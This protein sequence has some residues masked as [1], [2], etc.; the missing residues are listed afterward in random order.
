MRDRKQIVWCQVTDK[1]AVLF[2]F[3]PRKSMAYGWIQVTEWH[4][5]ETEALQEFEHW[6]DERFNY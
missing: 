3:P 4:K 6:F 5:T 1:C 2:D